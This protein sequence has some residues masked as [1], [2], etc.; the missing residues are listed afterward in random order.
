[1]SDSDL[2][3]QEPVEQ[4]A[5]PPGEPTLYRCSECGV[6]GLPERLAIHNCP[7]T[8]PCGDNVGERDQ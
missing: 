8:T 4:T 3:Q 1:M 6:V 2:T 5:K 7:G